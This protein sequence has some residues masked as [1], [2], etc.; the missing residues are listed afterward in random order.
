MKRLKRPD[1]CIVLPEPED[2]G[3]DEESLR[4]VQQDQL[5]MTQ[6]QNDLHCNQQELEHKQYELHQNQEVHMLYLL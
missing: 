5:E 3:F 1:E 6:N 2:V 4:Q